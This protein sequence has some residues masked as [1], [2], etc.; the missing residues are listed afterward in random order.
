MLALLW[1]LAGAFV[2]VHLVRGLRK[3][4][5][6]PSPASIQYISVLAMISLKA[7]PRFSSTCENATKKRAERGTL[8]Y[9]IRSL[10]M[11]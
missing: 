10:R 9:S 1:M 7:L 3:Q 8:I 5:D 4:G 6:P 11:G 2:L